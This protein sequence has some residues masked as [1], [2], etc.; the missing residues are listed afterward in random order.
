MSN[1][2]HLAG[3]PKFKHHLVFDTI[4]LLSAN[5][6]NPEQIWRNNE[7]LGACYIPGG[8]YNE[9][10][11]IAR[12]RKNRNKKKANQ[13]LSF[14]AKGGHYQVMPIE[15]NTKIPISNISDRQILTC[16]YQLAVENSNDVVI[17]VTYDKAQMG[18][19]AQSQLPNFCMIEAKE[20]AKWYHNGYYQNSL[21]KQIEET[22]SRL[23]SSRHVSQSSANSI[24]RNSNP[25]R[26]PERKEA[27][28]VEVE[29][30]NSKTGKYQRQ[31]SAKS[32]NPKRLPQIKS[33]NTSSTVRRKELSSE[34]ASL[35][36]K[37]TVSLLFTALII[38]GFIG[39]YVLNRDSSNLDINIDPETGIVV[40]IEAEIPTS[41][42][43]PTTPSKILALADNAILDFQ[44]TNSPENLIKAINELQELKNLQG[45]KLDSDGEEKLGKVKHK[46]AIEVLASR[47][48]V[49]KAIELLEQIPTTYSDYQL[50][51][52]WLVTQ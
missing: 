38:F 9:L 16:A 22:Y 51:Q 2:S 12:S 5:N 39:F 50:I 33:S 7:Q 6:T 42:V 15:E 25:K 28:P 34:N 14:L 44:Q 41:V 49:K 23:K 48:Q 43:T 19:V 45:G 18:L 4:A 1:L 31:S 13:F 21:P 26:L 8:T 30:Y 20:I 35:V 36:I 24:S 32:S 52:D 11:K 40:P 47:S 37:G 46:Y 29:T 3:R 10:T 27:R 17:L